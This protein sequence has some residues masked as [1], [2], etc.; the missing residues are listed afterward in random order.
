MAWRGRAGVWGLPCGR[1]PLWLGMG[2]AGI[3]GCRAMLLGNGSLEFC[4]FFHESQFLKILRF[5][6]WP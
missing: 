5:G 2:E 3:S 6:I 1:A 4:D